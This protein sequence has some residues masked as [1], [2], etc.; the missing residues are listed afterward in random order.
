M[1]AATRLQERGLLLVKEDLLAAAVI[2]LVAEA[3]F[4]AAQE[5]NS[6]I[7]IDLIEVIVMEATDHRVTI[8]YHGNLEENVV[9]PPQ[10]RSHSA[11]KFFR[12]TLI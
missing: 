11:D 6:K 7:A 2:D 4:K 8:R 1:T 5:D 9:L 12:D 10:I 3:V